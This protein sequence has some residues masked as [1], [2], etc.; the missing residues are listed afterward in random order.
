MNNQVKK[1][2]RP[3]L[4]VY[5]KANTESGTGSFSSESSFTSDMKFAAS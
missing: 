3:T 4:K 5:S 2:E 1:W